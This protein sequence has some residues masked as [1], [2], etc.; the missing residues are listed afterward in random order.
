VAK[1]GNSN[2]SHFTNR[3]KYDEFFRLNFIQSEK[4]IWLAQFDKPMPVEI[5]IEQQEAHLMKHA[6][7][8]EC[9]I[10]FVKMYGYEDPKE[11]IGVRFP[12]LFD[13]SEAVNVENLRSFLISNYKINQ[14]ESCEIGKNSVR[15]YFLNDIAG[16]I[17][18][19][20]LVRVWG[21]QKDITAEKSQKEIL[22]QLS[23]EQ[24]KILKA[25]VEGKTMKEMA[26]EVDISYKSVESLRNQNKAIIGVDT[27]AQLIATAVQLGINE[28]NV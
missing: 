20:N 27:I 3:N 2:S 1:N 8:S 9:N 28:F 7:L 21:I 12:Q 22:K 11:M 10:A 13:N 18:D 25:T 26:S 6:Y 17:E 24:M 16:V 5:P 14:I 4:G 23:S 19:N 15:K